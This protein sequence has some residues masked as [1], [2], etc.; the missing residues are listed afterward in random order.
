M[1]STELADSTVDLKNAILFSPGCHS[2]YNTV[3]AD[4]IPFV[5]LQPDWAQ[6]CARKQITLL[7]GTGYQYGDTDFIEY[8]EKIYLEFAKQL[9]SGA[10]AVPVGKALARAKEIYLATTPQMRGIQQKAFLEATL[11]GLPM[12]SVN[13]PGTRLPS[14]ADQS[15][16]PST[17]P[18]TTNPGLTLGLT[19]ANVTVT[20][21][22]TSHEV[23][24]T[25][26]DE[27][28]TA[29]A[30][31]LSGSDGILNNPAEPVLPLE[32]RNVS[33][34]GTVLRGVGFRGG[35]YANLSNLLPLTGARTTEIRGVH[36]AFLSD[37]FYPIKPWLVNYFDAVCND[38]NGATRLLVLPAQFASGP[39]NTA[40][41]TLRKYQT[42]DFR[43]FYSANTTTYTDP[44]SNVP[45]TPA[46][47]APP[48]I[49]GIEGI[50]VGTDVRLKVRVTGN[51]AAGIQQV[52]VTYTAESGPY[53]RH[54]Q[55]LDLDQSSADSTL[56]T[57]A[58][59]LNGTAPEDVRYM[60]QAV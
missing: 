1:L 15:I 39:S 11:F 23:T 32:V 5:T 54:W 24:L 56:W 50:T 21:S 19:F 37:F 47:S 10:G 31:Y 38:V 8:S 51:P 60:V 43:L 3:D 49:S 44:I 55:S 22:L 35:S 18:F 41:G 30:T 29:T 46:L 14:N 48:S 27:A 12:L 26:L 57:G 6:T 33:V 2:G 28:T 16:V 13:L 25:N 42:M 58:L 34:S 52:W 4:G 7:A 17:Q 53:P 45:S 36:T 40:T 9:R 59:P 20:P